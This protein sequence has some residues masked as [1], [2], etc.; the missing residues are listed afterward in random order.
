MLNMIS[1]LSKDYQAIGSFVFNTFG[2]HIINR[3]KN[4]ASTNYLDGG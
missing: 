4:Y 2:D 1:I 3:S